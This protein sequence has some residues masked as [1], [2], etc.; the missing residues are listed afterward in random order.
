MPGPIRKYTRRLMY[1]FNPF[2][3]DPYV[4]RQGKIQFPPL[5]TTDSRRYE[6]RAPNALF[7]PYELRSD[8]LPE[9]KT[10]LKLTRHYPVLCNNG[11]KTEGEDILKKTL[12]YWTNNAG[13]LGEDWETE[14]TLRRMRKELD[15]GGYRLSDGGGPFF[16]LIKDCLFDQRFT[17]KPS[18]FIGDNNVLSVDFV[19]PIKDG[20]DATLPTTIFYALEVAENCSITVNVDRNSLYRVGVRL[21][22]V[23]KVM[24][25]TNVMQ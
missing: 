14:E 5:S 25:T 4:S 10:Y 23:K 12:L 15:D 20:A 24:W 17:I 21:P 8:T 3:F 16:N 9:W 11:D 22:L 18:F 7:Y 2:R 1:A 13:T 19:R 6:S